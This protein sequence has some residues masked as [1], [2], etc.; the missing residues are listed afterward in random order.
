MQPLM[1]L[2]NILSGIIIQPGQNTNTVV[3]PNLNNNNPQMQSSGQGIEILMSGLNSQL[4]QI[5][6]FSS[7]IANFFMQNLINSGQ[8]FRRATEE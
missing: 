4:P 2:T 3:P 5:M 8:S 1:G 6:Q 7:Q